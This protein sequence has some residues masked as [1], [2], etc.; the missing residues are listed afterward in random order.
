MRIV[1]RIFWGIFFIMA[2][3]LIILNT[4]GKIPTISLF[5]LICTIFLV[6]T[7][8]ESTML[9]NIS[10]VLFSLAFLGILYAVPLGITALTPWPILM[11]ALLM[12]I[13][14]SII[15]GHHHYYFDHCSCHYEHSHNNNHQ[16]E[17]NKSDSEETITPTDDGIIDIRATMNG[18]VKYIN[19]DNFKVANIDCSFSGVK[20]YFD[21]AKI[22]GDSADINI[23]SSFSGIELY[24]PREWKITNNIDTVLGG[25]EEKNR[26]DYREQ[27]NKSD[28][29]SK[30]QIRLNGISKFSGIEII[31]I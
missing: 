19:T 1:R 24:I 3:V 26:M 30:K 16:C 7:L 20:V 21:K 9:L 25:L 2:A 29:T 10:G 6:A 12:S 14:F 22:L 31:Y 4:F 5:T 8:L 18:S 27:N 17:D 28:N 23:N 11:V 13:G 15:F